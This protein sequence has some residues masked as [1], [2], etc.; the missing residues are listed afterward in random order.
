MIEWIKSKLNLKA[1]SSSER[2]YEK[3][4]RDLIQHEMIRAMRN[5]VQHGDVNCLEHSLYVSYSS[6]MICRWLGFDYRSAAR[7]GLLHD[8]F[9]YDWHIG[10]PYKGLHGFI[11]PHIALQNANQYFNLNDREKDIIQKHMWPLTLRLPGCKEAFVV[12]LADKYCASMER[13]KFGNIKNINR[14][15]EI[16]EI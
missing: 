14:L 3:C 12:L 13:I 15:K 8:F 5:F 2:E 16:F 6:Y 10:K 11:H 4:I 7:G 1:D 9:L